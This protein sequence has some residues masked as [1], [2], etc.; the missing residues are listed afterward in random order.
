MTKKQLQERYN[1]FDRGINPGDLH[2]R[3][4]KT[5]TA[6]AIHNG[7]YLQQLNVDSIISFE[8]WR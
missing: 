4:E 3:I 1:L 6:I 5:D 2:V 7:L 8:W